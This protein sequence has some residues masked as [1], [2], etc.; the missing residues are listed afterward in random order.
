[1]AAGVG[2][3]TIP[4]VD[5]TGRQAVLEVTL[6]RDTVEW[7]ADDRCRAVFDFDELR[8]WFAN[9]SG[10]LSIDDVTFFPMA[11]SVA[12]SVAG[13]LSWRTIPEHIVADLR[14]RCEAG[15]A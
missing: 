1:M 4:F 15:R 6:R 2:R 14:R 13:Y 12:V 3:L 10:L 5:D 11:R 7:H 9:P 8:D